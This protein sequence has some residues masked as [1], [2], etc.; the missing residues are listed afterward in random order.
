MIAQVGKSRVNPKTIRIADGFKCPATVDKNNWT[1]E[2]PWTD[3]GDTFSIEQNGTQ[4]TVTRTDRNINEDGWYW[5]MYLK[6]KCC[7]TNSP[8]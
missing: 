1:V 8:F 6:F 4:V 3:Y 7:P 5:A 2:A